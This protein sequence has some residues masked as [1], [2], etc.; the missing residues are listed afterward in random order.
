M[1]TQHLDPD[2]LQPRTSPS[3]TPP[4]E[5]YLPKHLLLGTPPCAPCQVTVSVR[6]LEPCLAPSH[7]SIQQ[8]APGTK[9]HPASPQRRSVLGGAL[10]SFT[11][12]PSTTPWETECFPIPRPGSPSID[13]PI[14]SATRI[15][16]AFRPY[17]QCPCWV[18]SSPA[19]V[20]AHMSAPLAGPSSPQVPGAELLI[21]F[22][23][24][25]LLLRRTHLLSISPLRC[26][27]LFRNGPAS[28]WSAWW[29]SHHKP[30]FPFKGSPNGEK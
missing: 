8:T 1:D 24:L 17:P 20:S 19:A 3:S 25:G 26:P 13:Q 28:F 10:Q 15:T 12:P 29:E 23:S 6:C 21:P 14:S 22:G 30:Q 16:H 4:T 5:S 7:G 18:S 27:S 11:R 9:H 2:H